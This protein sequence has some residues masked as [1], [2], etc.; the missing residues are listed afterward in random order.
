MAM[1]WLLLRVRWRRALA[2]SLTVALLIG[3]IGGFVLASA[4]AA[5][6]VESTY[7][8]FIE[9]IDVPDIAVVPAVAC[10]I[11]RTCSSKPG[12]PDADKVLAEVNAMDVVEKARLIESVVPFLV[13]TPEHRSSERSTT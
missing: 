6:R 3:A 9:E 8:T 5:R 11:N 12:V 10:D 13:D 2:P 4:Q 7:R 1:L